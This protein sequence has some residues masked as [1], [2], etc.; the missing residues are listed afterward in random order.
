MQFPRGPVTNAL[1]II[2][3]AIAAI[4]LVPSLWQYAVVAGGLFPARLSGDSSAFADI[5]FLVPAL[6]TPLTAA[7]LHGGIAHVIMNMLMLLLIGKM[8]ERVWGGGL[9]LA[10]YMVS[11]YAAAATEWL[12]AYLQLPMSLD[13]MAP[14]IGASG[15]ISGVIGAYLLLFPNKQ[16]KRWGP[17]PASIARP[18]H[19]TLVWIGLNLA[20]G[21]VGP[22]LGI[23][24]AIW[25]HI[26]GFVMGLALARPL[27]LWRY[28]NA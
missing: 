19:L 15:A 18:L 10:L 14:A 9:F 26:G 6:L 7:F 17:V 1:V 8:V 12:A 5:T 27:L 25:S 3:L 21:F 2:N 11:A 4:L 23:G 13:M 24:I 16:P 22:G 20:M 28:R